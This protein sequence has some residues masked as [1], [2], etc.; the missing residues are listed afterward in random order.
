MGAIH[1]DSLEHAARY[2]VQVLNEHGGRVHLNCFYD[3]TEETFLRLR[4]GIGATEE[5]GYWGRAELVLAVAAGELVRRGYLVC[6]ELGEELAD[7]LRAFAI[8]LTD[9][10]RQKLASG[11]LPRFRTVEV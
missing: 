3:G 1:K 10:G 11:R 4:R 5:E 2:L 7:G 9:L 6:I 8:E